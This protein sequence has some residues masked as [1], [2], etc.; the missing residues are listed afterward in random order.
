MTVL[1]LDRL[2]SVRCS[3]EGGPE[4]SPDEREDE[5]ALATTAGDFRLAGLT[6]GPVS[7]LLANLTS[8]ISA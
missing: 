4:A 2:E 1:W 3:R 6:G 5:A 8:E 7:L